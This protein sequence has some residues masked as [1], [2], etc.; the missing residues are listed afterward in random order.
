MSSDSHVL[1]LS[2]PLANKAP[3]FA[4][5]HTILSVYKTYSS[6]PRSVPELQRR[7]TVGEPISIVRYQYHGP[8]QV[9]EAI[10]QVAIK[11]PEHILRSEFEPGVG[12]G[13][14][15][16]YLAVVMVDVKLT[17]IPAKCVDQ[18][19]HVSKR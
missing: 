2:F 18:N 19:R 7:S 13:F 3:V 17:W 12:V 5:V 15:C 11:S 9:Q 6:M 10:V 4:W 1:F 16:D 8:N 14:P